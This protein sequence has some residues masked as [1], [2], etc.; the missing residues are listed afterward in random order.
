M[1]TFIHT[2]RIRYTLLL[3]ASLLAMLTH[4]TRE[5]APKKLTEVTPDQVILTEAQQAAAGIQTGTL[6]K[7]NIVRTI[8]ATGKVDVP[9]QN[10]VSISA[11]LGGFI[12]STH[13]LQ[14]MR[15]KKGEVIAVLENQAYIQ[16]QQ[17]Y[18][19]SKSKLEFLE[20]EYNRQTELYKENVNAQKAL[21]Q[22]KSSYQSMAATVHGLEA[23]LRMIGITPAMLHDNQIAAQV[24]LLAPIT[25]YVAEV[26]VNTGQYVNDTFVA[27]KL[28]DTDHM[29]VEL[30]VFEKDIP[31][32]AIG[33]Q[34][35]YLLP[36]NA[37]QHEATVYLIG[38]EISPERTVRVH[39]HLKNDDATLLPGMF[40][41]AT[42]ETGAHEATVLP[43]QAV[44][45]FEGQAHVFVQ[46]KPGEYRMVE[47]E[48]LGTHDNYT[49]IRLPEGLDAASTFVVKGAF[50]L[51]GM[52]KN[53]GE[54][55]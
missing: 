27:F 28:V 19:D 9:P 52:V 38:K 17:D 46:G 4:C 41:T 20:A 12:R 36:S 1:T 42:I 31:A 23:K 2:F 8:Q 30:Q 45:N 51:L 7:K 33:Q 40:V 39:C 15:V 47:V 29:H 16:L 13:L 6:E 24:S 35:L 11:P 43:A 44:V 48:A 25:G 49:E 18:L 55:E 50:E 26:N 3:S 21:Q 5:A 37:M 14:G 22:A 34:V 10:M 54:E 32:L 53:T